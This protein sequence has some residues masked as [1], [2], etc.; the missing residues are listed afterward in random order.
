MKYTDMAQFTGK[1]KT[2]VQ[3][4]A[5][6]KIDELFP[7][8]PQLRVFAKRGV[9]N[10]LTRYDTR[11]NKALDTAM[12][13]VADGNGCID[14]D[15]MVDT[16]VALF[17]EMEVQK[18]TVW[19]MDV[20]VGRGAVTINFPHNMVFDMLLGNLGQVKFTADDFLELKDLLA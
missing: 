16:V 17:N 14:S 19:G 11:I 10:I 8:K 12:L 4:W 1:C 6:K 18:Y 5:D 13:F 2:A 3:Q 7:Y 20:G 9:D 15:V